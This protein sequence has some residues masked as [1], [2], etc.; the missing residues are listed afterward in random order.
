M[1]QP[2]LTYEECR[3]ALESIMCHVFNIGREIRFPSKG[4][5]YPELKVV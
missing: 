2:A 4:Y 5:T 3:G 1:G